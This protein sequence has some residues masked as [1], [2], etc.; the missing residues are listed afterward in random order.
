MGSI[1]SARDAP[2]R[3]PC[4]AQI[5]CFGLFCAPRTRDPLRPCAC[6]LGSA[7]PLYA[8]SRSRNCKARTCLPPRAH[9]IANPAT[10]IVEQV[11]QAPK[12]RRGNQ[13]SYSRRYVLFHEL[14]RSSSPSL[15]LSAIRRPLRFGVFPPHTP[16]AA[17]ASKPPPLR[18]RE[19]AGVCG[20]PHPFEAERPFQRRDV[21]IKSG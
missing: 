8:W 14:A 4:W 9:Y 16:R 5:S 10:K 20:C 1:L 13:P 17:R 7:W 6:P 12:F 15:G 2:Q 3:S 18:R 11:P 19:H 21:Q